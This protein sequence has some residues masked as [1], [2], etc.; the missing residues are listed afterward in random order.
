MLFDEQ[1]YEQ[2][3]AVATIVR[4]EANVTD[5]SFAYNTAYAAFRACTVTYTPSQG[6]DSLKAT[7]TPQGAPKSGPILKINEQVDSQ[8]DAMRLARK[9]LREKIK[10]AAKALSPLWEI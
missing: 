2:K 9:R 1:E 7:Y 6:K 3:E 5:Y 8:A 10:R 4:G